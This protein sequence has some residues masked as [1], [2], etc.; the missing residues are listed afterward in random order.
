MDR[1]ERNAGC[2]SHT[3]TGRRFSANLFTEIPGDNPKTFLP[4]YF[5]VKCR[6]TGTPREK[7]DGVSQ[8]TLNRV[9]LMAYQELIKNFERIRDYMRQ[10]YVFGFKSREEYD[11]K[12]A[13]SYDDERRRIESWLGDHMAFRQ[14]GAGKNVFLSVDSRRIPHNPLYKAF[15]A[16]SFTGRD[17]ALHFYILDILQP[18]EVRTAGELAAEIAS[19]YLSA[20]PEEYAFDE[21]T[22][23]K[24]LKEYVDLGLLTRKKQGREVLYRRGPEFDLTP[25]Q[26]AAAFFSES[27][28][29]GVVGSYILDRYETEPAAFGFK[30]HYLLHA[31]DSQVLLSLL[32]CIHQGREAELEILNPRREKDIRQTVRPVC[33]YISTQTGRQYLLCWRKNRP[34]FVRLDNIRKVSPGK[35]VPGPPPE[36][37]EDLQGHLWGVSLGGGGSL[38]HIEMTLRIEEGEEFIAQRLEREKRC[39]SVE[40][41]PGGCR[42]S[43]DVRDAYELLPWLRT[44]I[45]RITD[46]QCSNPA[47]TE[48]F[49]KDLAALAELYGTGT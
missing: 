2:S 38:E 6:R 48:T 43:A 32:E 5:V 15:K 21:S 41:V 7:Q 26:D 20:F 19:D 27:S 40:P 44:F 10:F 1:R 49:R 18:G 28:P 11:A 39:G 8:T 42:F 24:K 29:L 36:A 22:I 12:S 17:I 34:R 4:L 9:L 13:R 33:I 23:R 16:K 30:H 14:D 31:L 46:L 37:L 45:G 35:P 3:K 47:V 25:W